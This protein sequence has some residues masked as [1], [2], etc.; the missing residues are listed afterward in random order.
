M[1]QQ[2]RCLVAATVACFAGAVWAA[3]WAVAPLEAPPT[4]AAITRPDVRPPIQTADDVDG[5]TSVGAIDF[6]FSIQKPLYDPPPPPPKPQQPARFVPK[7]VSR[8]SAP[9]PKLNWTLVG[10]II[11]PT[12]RL[13]ILSDESGKTDIRR[14]GETIELAPPGVQ[15]KSIASEKVILD[16]NGATSTLHL[17]KTLT[18]SSDDRSNVRGNRRRNR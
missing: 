14:V 16:V 11:D 6:S 10:T 8:P 12:Q 18:A 13:A 15:V 5:A 9:K 1:K 4:L 7:P 3:V 2:Q 17:K